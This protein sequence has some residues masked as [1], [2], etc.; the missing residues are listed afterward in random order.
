MDISAVGS[1]NLQN[2]QYIS[3]NLR[4]RS[5]RPVAMSQDSGSTESVAPR[6]NEVTQRLDGLS[7]IQHALVS[8]IRT[9]ENI[10][11]QGLLNPIR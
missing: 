3:P 5:Q 6:N 4:S 11:R 1:S 7:K 8:A 2:L 10:E 9:G